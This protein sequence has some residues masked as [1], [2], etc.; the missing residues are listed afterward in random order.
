MSDHLVWIDCE[1]TGLDLERDALIEIAV[2]VTDADLNILG[3]GVDLVIAPPA[4]AL[5]TMPD[6]VR[7]MHTSSGLLD[8]LADGITMED[9]QAQALAYIREHVP[10][11]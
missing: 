7:K 8:V 9:A 3:E 1:M 6:I 11:A 5:E 10:E 2:L 4:E